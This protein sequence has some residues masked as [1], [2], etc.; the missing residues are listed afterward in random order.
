[1]PPCQKIQKNRL[2]QTRSK[3]KMSEEFPFRIFSVPC[4][5]FE[6]EKGEKKKV[7]V[8]IAPIT[9]KHTGE[10]Y[11]IGWACNRGLFCKDKTCRYSKHA[12]TP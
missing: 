10:T 2:P 9:I 12:Y 3:T 6:N 7:T 11:E 4:Y 1:M 5:D 8:I